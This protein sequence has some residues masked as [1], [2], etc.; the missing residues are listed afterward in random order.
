MITATGLVKRYDAKS[1]HKLAVSGLDFTVPEGKL[2]TLLG[3]SGCGKTTTLRM[4]AGLE[5]PSEGRLEIAG[6]VVFDSAT[7][8]FA[9]A[10]KRPIGMVFQSYAIWPHMSVVENVA[11]P[12]TVGDHKPTRAE[13]RS[14]ALKMLDLVGLA[15]EA[16]RPA[17]AI[18]G[19]QQQRVALARALVREPSVLLLDEPLSNLDAQLRERMRSEIRLVQQQLG[20]T[21]VYVTHDQSEALAI[22]DLI[23]IMDKGA[24]VETGLPQQIYRYPQAEFT[25]NF[26]GVAN[27]IDGTVASSDA[28][29]LVIRAAAGT[30]RAAAIPELRAGDAV[31]VFVRPENIEL[32]RRRHG[33]DDWAGV[34]RFSIYQGDC[35]DYTVEVAGHDVRVRVHKERLD[36][37]HGDPIHLR[38]S[39]SEAVV[40]RMR[41]GV[42]H[43][44]APSAP[45]SNELVGMTKGN[46]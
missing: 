30:M 5:R 22:S 29:G 1:A 19:G 3:P 23:M 45:P 27:A 9:P 39:A 12:L 13:A 37:G 20:I 44:F 26:I 43:A 11:F 2:F 40:M 15:D 4:I 8:A 36:L 10:N 14:R 21:A 24:I 42:A 33:D 41:D 32:S 17:T 28:S 6:Q 25:A 34:V 16:D 7:G 38:P 35:W 46:A 18:S 31:R